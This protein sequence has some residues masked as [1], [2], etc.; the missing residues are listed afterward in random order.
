MRAALEPRMTETQKLRG[1]S[2]K[3]AVWR[4]NIEN[5][6]CKSSRAGNYVESK[7]VKLDGIKKT[8]SPNYSYTLISLM[9]RNKFFTQGVFCL[10]CYCCPFKPLLNSSEVCWF[11]RTLTWKPLSKTRFKTHRFHCTKQ[12]FKGVVHKPRV[13]E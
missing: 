3:L 4:T 6:A 10:F 12:F 1:H 7:L 13:I 2:I 9:G 8:C 11:H 5:T